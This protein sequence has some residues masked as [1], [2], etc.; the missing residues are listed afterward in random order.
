MD[1]E[2]EKIFAL[3]LL[4]IVAML[5]INSDKALIGQVAMLLT[6]SLMAGAICFLLDYLL[7]R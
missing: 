4:T 2:D 7:R 1:E 5:M 3:I 6:V